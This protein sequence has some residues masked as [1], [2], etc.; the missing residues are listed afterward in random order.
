V[1]PV[2]SVFT[3]DVLAQLA[4]RLGIQPGAPLP[5]VDLIS[6]EVSPSALYVFGEFFE[7]H[8]YYVNMPKPKEPPVRLPKYVCIVVDSPV[9][10]F[11][12]S[13]YRDAFIAELNALKCEFKVVGEANMTSAA[14]T[15]FR[16]SVEH[17]ELALIKAGVTKVLVETLGMKMPLPR[18]VHLIHKACRFPLTLVHSPGPLPK[19]PLAADATLSHRFVT[20]HVGYSRPTPIPECA[21]LTAAWPV[22]SSGREPEGFFAGD[23]LAIRRNSFH[24]PRVP[25]SAVPPNAVAGGYAVQAC[26]YPIFMPVNRSVFGGFRMMFP[27]VQQVRGFCVVCSVEECYHFML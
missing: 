7:F 6:F 16:A 27:R 18:A 10:V 2:S 9:N 12:E 3:S 11:M 23:W 13:Q 17:I 20:L 22:D 26:N 25:R 15:R 14:S 21:I 19:S 8:F 5:D 24:V 4:A 1:L